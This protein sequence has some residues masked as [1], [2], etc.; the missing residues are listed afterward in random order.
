MTSSSGWFYD[1]IK[2]RQLKKWKVFEGFA[3]YLKNLSTDF[4][5]TFVIFRALSVVSFKIEG[6]K[7]GHSL[8]PW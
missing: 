3:E 2:I 8:L 1:V 4:Y 7:T 5:Q 6:L